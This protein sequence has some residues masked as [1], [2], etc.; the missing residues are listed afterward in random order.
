MSSPVEAL[1]GLLAQI[2]APGS[3]A[4]RRT[5]APNDL[6]LEIKGVGRLKFPITPSTA[7]KLCAAGLLA[8]HGHKDQ[9]RLDRRVR[10]TWEIPKG[11][12][13]I[14]QR[15]WK[16]TLQPHLAGIRRELGLPETCR[17]RAAL[18]NLLIYEPG[19]NRNL[20]PLH[21]ACREC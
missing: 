2:N 9:T 1:P 7:V 4:T 11:R 8:R 18:H 5:A 13:S 12:I 20:G 16:R 3:F 14:D 21:G 15:T 17:L 6:R 19:H 10:D